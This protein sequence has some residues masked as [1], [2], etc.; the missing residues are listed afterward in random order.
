MIRSLFDGNYRRHIFCQFCIKIVC[1]HLLETPLS[2]V[3]VTSAYKIYFILGEKKKEI[4][5][6]LHVS[7]NN[8]LIWVPIASVLDLCILFTFNL[9]FCQLSCDVHPCIVDYKLTLFSFQ[10]NGPS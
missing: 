4:I 7:R 2:D 6:G 8:Y 9:F 10:K 5:P 1:L 3:I